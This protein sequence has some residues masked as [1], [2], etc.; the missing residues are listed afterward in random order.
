MNRLEISE[1]S[2]SDLRQILRDAVQVEN[3]LLRREVAFLRAE[4]RKNLRVVTLKQATEFFDS[5]VKPETILSYIKYEGLPGRKNNRLWHLYVEDIIDWQIGLIGHA[6]TKKQGISNV[7]PPRHR[8]NA[9]VRMAAEQ[10][11]VPQ[12]NRDE[13]DLTRAS[14]KHLENR[15]LSRH[16]E[17]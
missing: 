4:F 5:Y 12:Q 14:K 3:D 1:I 8:H 13:L 11:R 9:F 2:I 10:T 15:H 7:V 17:I 16:H 6:S